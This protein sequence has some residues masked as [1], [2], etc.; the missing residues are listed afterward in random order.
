MSVKIIYKD[1]ALGADADAEVTTTSAQAFS[2]T[3]LIPFGAANPAFATCEH[4]GWGLTHDYVVRDTQPIA[5]WSNNTSNAS[6]HFASSAI[7]KITL[8]FSE[9]YSSTGLTIRFAPEAMDYCTKIFVEWYRNDTL[10]YG[11]TFTPDS[12]IFIINQP[13]EAFNKIVIE[14]MDTNLPYR[15]CKV[16]EILIGVI[17]EFDADELKDVSAVHQIDL[18]SET[19]PINVLD[20]EIH[21]NENID[22]IFQKKQPVAVYNDGELVGNYF[23]EKGK[24]T[25]QTDFALSCQ[26]AIGLLELATTKGG[27]WLEDTPLTEILNTAIKSPVTFEIDTAYANSTL[28]GFIQ[29]DIKEREALQ[30]IAFALGAIVDTSNSTKIRIFPPPETVNGDIPATETY[31]GG[32]VDTSDTVTEVTVTAYII[33]DERPTDNEQSIEYNGIKYKYYTETKH[34]KNPNTVTSDPE[35]I[36]KFD[37]SYLCNLSNAQTLADKLMAHYQKRDKYTFSHILNGQHAGGKYTGFLPW[38]A[39][40]QGIITKMSLS[41]SNMTVCNTEMVLDE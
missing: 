10:I 38:E 31:I 32:T 13:I 19:I 21:S 40:T 1:I 20:A 17:R 2:Q 9:Q 39:A 12:P 35:N 16:E 15:R 27:L 33:S 3:D 34:A 28:R 6:C 8:T 24:K 36:K 18:T 7:P 41:L 25:S 5:F 26:D 11:D 23:I 22:F 30:Q 37:K 4:N 14:F 29:P